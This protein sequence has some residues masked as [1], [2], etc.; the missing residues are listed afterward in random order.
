[1]GFLHDVFR[2]KLFNSALEWFHEM[3]WD[4][5]RIVGDWDGILFHRQVDFYLVAISCCLANSLKKILVPI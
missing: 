3:V 1:M 2:N 5:S 4:T